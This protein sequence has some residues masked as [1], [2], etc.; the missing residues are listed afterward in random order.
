MRG[1]VCVCGGGEV[2]VGGELLFEKKETKL[3]EWLRLTEIIFP[4]RFPHPFK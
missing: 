2:G 1:G 3:D 4:E